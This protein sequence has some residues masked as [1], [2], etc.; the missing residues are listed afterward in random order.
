MTKCNIY[1]NVTLDVLNYN[2]HLKTK[3]PLHNKRK[4][5]KLLDFESI[6]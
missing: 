2:K 4:C 6:S 1:H 3:T 5:F